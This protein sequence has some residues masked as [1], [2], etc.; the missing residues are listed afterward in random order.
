MSPIVQ[1]N[2]QCK[3]DQ[4][5]VTFGNKTGAKYKFK[6]YKRCIICNC[7]R[8]GPEPIVQSRAA[9]ETHNHWLRGGRSSRQRARGHNHWLERGEKQQIESQGPQPL[10]GQ[11][12]DIERTGATTTCWSGGRGRGQR[13]RDHNH[14]LVRGQGERIESKGPQPLVSYLRPDLGNIFLLLFFTGVL[15]IT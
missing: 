3:V 12:E 1:T 8:S 10:V 6:M 13:A 4:K 2:I 5:F 9:A 14:W 15:K 11:G 7:I